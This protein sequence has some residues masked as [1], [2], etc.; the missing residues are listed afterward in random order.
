MKN[1]T[2]I[3]TPINIKD[4]EDYTEESINANGRWMNR[5]RKLRERRWRKNVNRFA[6]LDEYDSRRTRYAL[7]SK[8]WQF[9]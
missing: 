1:I 2:F 8:Q 4:P 5:A 9:K 7:N 6:Q 3:K